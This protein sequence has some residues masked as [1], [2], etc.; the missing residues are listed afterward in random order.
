MEHGQ[1][2]S[3]L[4]LQALKIQL[5]QILT[6]FHVREARIKLLKFQWKFHFALYFTMGHDLFIWNN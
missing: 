3:K 1:E 4:D 6:K 5:G 2:L